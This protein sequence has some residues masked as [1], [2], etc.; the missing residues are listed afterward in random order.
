VA[1][2]EP[3]ATDFAYAIT[4]AQGDRATNFP[5]VKNDFAARDSLLPSRENTTRRVGSR[6]S[7]TRPVIASAPFAFTLASTQATIA[8]M[9]PGAARAA[10]AKKDPP[11]GR[12]YR[13]AEWRDASRC[14]VSR[15]RRW[16]RCPR[17]P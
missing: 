14:A 11:E 5:C 13:I 8:R 4:R 1:G 16:C 12:V 15:R 2:I 3:G 17:H 6:H 7:L 10:E 9:L